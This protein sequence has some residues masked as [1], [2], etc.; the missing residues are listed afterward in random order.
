VHLASIRNETNAYRVEMFKADEN[1]E[2][3]RSTRKERVTVG[4]KEIG[5][6]W[7]EFI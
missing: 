3:E 5:W 1:R 4:L 7:T 6:V 2:L